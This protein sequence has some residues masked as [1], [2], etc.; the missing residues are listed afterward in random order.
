MSFRNLKLFLLLGGKA[1]Q[2]Q[3]HGRDSHLHGSAR[4]WC[5]Q[6]AQAVR[7]GFRYV[8]SL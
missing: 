7:S 5:Q 6:Q 4:G 2:G 3:G 8:K 1:E